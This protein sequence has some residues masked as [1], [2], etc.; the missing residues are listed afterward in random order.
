MSPYPRAGDPSLFAAIL[1]ETPPPTM[2]F[3]EL[4]SEGGLIAMFE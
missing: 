2:T 1:S 3:F 4:I